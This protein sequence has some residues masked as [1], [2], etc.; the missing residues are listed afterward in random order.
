MWHRDQ[1][2]QSTDDDFIEYFK[3]LSPSTADVEIRSLSVGDNEAGGNELLHFIQALTSRVAARKDY[4]L[5]QAWMA[6]FLR[7]HSDIIME[8]QPLL[9][10]LAEW[11]RYQA[12]ECARLDDLVGYCS[13]VVGFLRSPRT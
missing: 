10:A 6:V 12:Q 1:G 8:S 13:G 3:N 7:L 11:K 9:S 2:S 4:E 5:V